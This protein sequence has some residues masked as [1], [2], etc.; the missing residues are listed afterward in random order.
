MRT[1]LATVLAVMAI[2]V[3]AL[4]NALPAQAT[5]TPSGQENRYHLTIPTDGGDCENSEGRST[6]QYVEEC[7]LP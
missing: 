4:G 6:G 2:A 5:S 3:P 1:S 7:Y